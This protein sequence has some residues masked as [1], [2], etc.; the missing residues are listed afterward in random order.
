M[1]TI[2]TLTIDLVARYRRFVDGVSRSQ[3]ALIGLNSSVSKVIGPMAALAGGMTAVGTAGY[4]MSKGIRNATSFQQAMANSTAIMT[5]LTE[6]ME[7]KMVS[8]AQVMSHDTK[9][10]AQQGAEA[11]YFLASAGLD[12]EQSIAALP[13]VAKFAQA[14]NFDL[15]LA[16]D[17]ATDA[18][19][20]LGLT[21]KDSAKNLENLTRVTDVLTKANTLANASSQQ[22]SEAITNGVGATLKNANKDIEEGVAVLAAYADQGI[23]GEEAGTAF[24]IVVRDLTTKA[25]ENAKA[26]EMAGIAVYDQA[27]A[28][29]NMAD[30]IYDV[31]QSLDGLSD[32]EKKTTLLHLGFAD[33]SLKFIQTLI[34][35]SDKIRDYE[36][37][38]QDAGGTTEDVANRQLTPTT[39]AL[40]RLSAGFD[41]FTSSLFTPALDNMAVSI[42]DVGD[43]LFEASVSG[44]QFADFIGNITN[45]V[46]SLTGSFKSLGSEVSAWLNGMQAT[47]AQLE[48]MALDAQIAV[49]EA[50]LSIN[51]GLTE[52]FI[53]KHITKKAS[54]DKLD[55]LLGRRERWQTFVDDVNSGAYAQKQLEEATQKAARKSEEQADAFKKAFEE[56]ENVRKSFLEKQQLELDQ[57]K[58]EQMKQQLTDSLMTPLEN[59]YQELGNIY[60]LM[61][62]NMI[63]AQMFD[64]AI[65]AADEKLAGQQDRF[66]ALE[67]P[68]SNIAVQ[69]GS[70]AAMEAV[71]R[72]I[73]RRAAEAQTAKQLEA[74]RAQIEAAKTLKKIDRNLKN[75]QPIQIQQVSLV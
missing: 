39:K 42:T 37:A 20:A 65:A 73:N 30:I 63:S 71:D 18:Q 4:L 25:L 56:Q 49:E 62:A 43:G 40:A 16:T 54:R 10:S 28:M 58:L 35:T 8:A 38:L 48:V 74:Q 51:E 47:W 36:K 32:A 2:D 19:S 44:Q 24:G 60:D 17:L 6:D 12:A 26:F 70:A 46:V 57:S 55:E 67:A 69:S 41:K 22:F 11:F 5:N 66:N 9:F 13:Q 61:N 53:F 64:R 14:G 75:N 68:G 59:Y 21:V 34:G 7:A 1:A 27:G 15:A 45:D 29:R 31:E 3:K 23:K 72:F 50:A 33:K 52:D